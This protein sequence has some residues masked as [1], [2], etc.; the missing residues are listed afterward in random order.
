MSTSPRSW[1]SG[2][3]WLHRHSSLAPLAPPPPVPQV[4]CPSSWSLTHRRACPALPSP[5]SGRITTVISRP[6]SP[7]RGDS[8]GPPCDWKDGRHGHLACSGFA[9]PGGRRPSPALPWA[10]L[11][12]FPVPRTRAHWAGP[13]GGSPA[14][15]PGA[16]EKDRSCQV[17]G[18]EPGVRPESCP[19][20]AAGTMV[21][22]ARWALMLVPGSGWKGDEALE[23]Y[24]HVPAPS[25]GLG[26][27]QSGVGGRPGPPPRRHLHR[28]GALGSGAGGGPRALGH[29]QGQ[30]GTAVLGHIP[31]SVRPGERRCGWARRGRSAPQWPLEPS[32]GGLWLSPHAAPRHGP[33]SKAPF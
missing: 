2:V 4:Q 30:P 32:A 18:P 29:G 12:L 1:S 26:G 20:P 14:A 8:Q 19:E 3:R 16:S 27:R 24:R 5:C 17:K 22:R 33:W 28:H 25:R 15:Q 7:T 13:V 23:S 6:V 11:A 10:Y 31:C 9:R 21:V